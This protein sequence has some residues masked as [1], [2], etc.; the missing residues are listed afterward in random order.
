MPLS[1]E[2]PKS[3]YSIYVACLAAYNNGC[4]HGAWIDATQEPEEIEAEVQAMLA[5]SPIPNAEEWAIHDYDLG[6]VKISEY[7]SFATVSALAKTLD[8][9]GAAWVAYIGHIGWEYS[10]QDWDATTEK[11]ENAY[12]GEWSSIAA[13][14]EDFYDSIHGMESIPDLVRYHINWESLGNS[15]AIDD[16]WTAPAPGGIYVFERN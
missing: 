6:G 7:E 11:F 2:K 3:K 10:A 1:T 9:H 12:R 14:S 5:G 8:E 15:M 13:F 4:L 16:V